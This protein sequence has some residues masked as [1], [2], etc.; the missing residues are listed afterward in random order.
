MMC[1]RKHIHR[2]RCHYSIIRTQHRKI[3]GLCGRITTY[4][5]N[6]VRGCIEQVAEIKAKIIGQ[7]PQFCCIV[8]YDGKGSLIFVERPLETE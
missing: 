3:A 7:P 1:L 5:H 2:Y 6:P 4:I 8:L